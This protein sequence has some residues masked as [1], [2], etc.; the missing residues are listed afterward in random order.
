MHIKPVLSVLKSS[1]APESVVNN[2]LLNCVM[3]WWILLQHVFRICENMISNSDVLR[4]PFKRREEVWP[5]Q[6]LLCT[7]HAAGSLCP[8]NLQLSG[9]IMFKEAIR[10][11]VLNV[12]L[13]NMSVQLGEI[14][15]W[16]CSAC[17]CINNSNDCITCLAR[18]LIIAGAQIFPLL[19]QN[20]NLVVDQG[21][22]TNIYCIVLYCKDAKWY[23]NKFL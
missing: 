11:M 2:Q 20:W 17:F 4:Q 19:G 23:H 9:S 5:L 8:S 16:S 21:P 1:R 13:G 12:P 22:E 7:M 6:T 18:D 10:L 15:V 14:C 3:L